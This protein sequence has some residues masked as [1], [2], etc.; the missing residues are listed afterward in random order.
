MDVLWA[1]HTRLEFYDAGV[2]DIYSDDPRLELLIMGAVSLLLALVNIIGI[3][4]AGIVVL[5]VS[6]YS[7]VSLKA[8]L[9]HI[10]EHMFRQGLMYIPTVYI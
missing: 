8:I 7:C 5:K 3:F 4:I 9:N 10:C 2:K 1:G 6:A